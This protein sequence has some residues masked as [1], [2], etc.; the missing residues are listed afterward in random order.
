L[1]CRPQF[2]S[3]QSCRHNLSPGRGT[4]GLFIPGRF[5]QKYRALCAGEIS[6][7][8]TTTGLHSK[9]LE[10]VLLSSA[11]MPTTFSKSQKKGRS[12]SDLGLAN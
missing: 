10:I 9:N 2:G 6:F 1:A 8:S 4:V 12:S 5:P 3:R 7:A 11:L